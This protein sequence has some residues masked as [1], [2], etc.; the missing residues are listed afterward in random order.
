M[1]TYIGLDQWDGWRFRMEP[2]P[3]GFMIHQESPAKVAFSDMR[4]VADHYERIYP[5]W[6]ERRIEQI[7]NRAPCFVESEWLVQWL[8][9]RLIK[10]VGNVSVSA[11]AT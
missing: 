6:T 3:D 9:N 5:G 4:A 11:N 10:E 7:N 8:K 2:V 1:K